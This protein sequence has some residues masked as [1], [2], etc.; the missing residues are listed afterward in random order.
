MLLSVSV[1]L[2][3]GMLLMAGCFSNGAVEFDSKCSAFEDAAVSKTYFIEQIEFKG[4]TALFSKE[5]TRVSS[6]DV[7]SVSNIL[8]KAFTEA[9][10]ESSLR[11]VLSPKEAKDENK[12]MLVGDIYRD[13][14]RA[15]EVA[16]W[17]A[18]NGPFAGNFIRTRNAGAE[19]IS[20][21]V[22][23]SRKNTN[24]V[25][26]S[27]NNFLAVCTIN[28]WPWYHSWSLDYYVEVK[29]VAGI[30]SEKFSLHE[31]SLTSWL[32]P[33]ALCPVPAWA[34]YRDS[35]AH[36]LEEGVESKQI[37]Q[38]VIFLLDDKANPKSDK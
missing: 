18:D 36:P 37:G 23:I 32:L 30:N 14:R 24:G 4:M 17:L 28:I 20:I 1:V 15:L 29:S 5:K 25:I 19:P 27:L 9:L 33:L 8:G 12:M 11:P 3:F 10:A 21:S 6:N 34:D 16:N 26:A 7:T 2:A 35:S 13:K 31:Q 38:C 22:G